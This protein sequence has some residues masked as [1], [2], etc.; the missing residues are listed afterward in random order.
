[1]TTPPFASAPFMAQFPG[2]VLTPPRSPLYVEGIPLAQA[3]LPASKALQAPS[4][5]RFWSSES[6]KYG[7]QTNEMMIVTL[8]SARLLNYISLDLPHFPSQ[9]SLAWRD[10]KGAWHWIAGPNG[11]VLQFI[12]TGSVPPVVNSAAA[13]T[14]G[15]NPY[16]YGAGHW[17]HYD[18]PIKPVTAGALL[19]AGTRALQTVINIAPGLLP[20]DASGRNCP[21]PLG[22]RNLDF[23]YRVFAPTDAPYR[24]RH[25]EIVTERQSFAVAEDINGSPVQLSMRENRASDLLNGVPWKCAPQPMS[26]AVVSL[27][28]DVRGPAGQAQVIDRFYI[29]PTTSGVSL[30]LY[31]A[32]TPP[33]AGFQAVDTPLG[34]PFA[35]VNGSVLPAVDTEGLMFSGAIGWLDLAAQ[36]TGIDFTSPWWMAWEIQ[37]QF[38]AADP[39]S[40]MVADTG[41]VQLWYSAGTWYFT[42]YGGGN[43]GPILA[44]WPAAH[45]ANDRLQFAAGW[46]GEL[47]SCWSAQGG[48]MT[49]SPVTRLPATSIIRFGAVQQ[50]NW[51]LTIW[52]GNYRLTSYILKQEAPAPDLVAGG[53]PAQFTEFAAGPQAYTAPPDGP[54][55]TT[56]NA[57]ARF[58][59]SLVLGPPSTGLAPYGFAGGLGTA[60]T[61]ATW[62]PVQLSYRL[63]AGLVQF[64][65]VL[66]CG[67]KFEF[68]NLAPAPYE[69][70]TETPQ[71][72]KVFP[73]TPPDTQAGQPP[74]GS[75]LTSARSAVLSGPN[76]S[77]GSQP[78]PPSADNGMVVNAS[79][80]PQNFYADQARPRTPPGPG[81]ALPTEALYGTDAHAAEA[82][83]RQGGSLYNFQPWLA[84]PQGAPKQAV[85]GPEIYQEVSVT[86]ASRVAYFAGLARLVMYRVDYTATN[87]TAEYIDTFGDTAGIDPA[88]LANTT[89]GTTI[90]WTWTPGLLSVPVNLPPGSVAQ[91]SS[92]VFSS[93]HQV[94]GV[95]FAALEAAPYQLLPDPGFLD[96]ALPFVAAVGDALPLTVSAGTSSPLGSLVMCSRAP[97]Q[98]SWAAM[99]ASYPLW[100]AFTAPALSWLQLE[101]NPATSPYGGLAYT[102]APVTVSAAGRVHIAA[103]VFAAQAL[104]TPLFLQ[105]LDGATGSV[106]AEQQVAAAGGIV[107]EWFASF[108]LGAVQAPSS[109][110][111]AQ[112]A[113]TYPAWNATVGQPWSVIDTFTP[114]LGNTLSWQLIQYGLTSDIWGVDDVSIFEDSIL[115][116]F[117]NDGGSTWWPA[118]D[119]NANP[120]GALVF[121]VPAAGT[122]NKLSWRLLGYRPNLT[123]GSLAVR[124]WYSCYPRG[125]PP[126]VPGLPHGPN[127]SHRDHYGQIENDP[128][129]QTWSGPVPQAWYFAYSQLLLQGTSYVQPDP[130]PL[131]ESALLLGRGLVVPAAELATGPVTYSDIYSDRYT[132]GYGVPDGSDIFTDNGG[133]GVYQ[134]YTGPTP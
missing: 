122:G 34:G 26:R 7:D 30:N 80:A 118:Y 88:S 48:T 108:T 97:G 85:T 23:G 128:Y 134:S 99:M 107:T 79:L 106:L 28:A 14:A 94:T 8:S 93:A 15:Q 89:T 25:P 75:A 46:D 73:V 126:R 47:L 86:A 119:V 18:E 65:P 41:I 50:P 100:S 19:V 40:Y 104:T 49:M 69:F 132:Y 10:A 110:T 1:M 60:W 131:P 62:I 20:R 115:W 42:Q 35:T 101:G 32:S 102:G 43:P 58:D 112:V 63:T 13:L 72:A 84:S 76:S 105:L 95:Q 27:Y 33:A 109:Y 111:W 124:P 54:G 16:H 71:K 4:G 125:V 64:P 116:E 78:V 44:S 38:G 12:I 90:P 61:S 59:L 6:R 114:P 127:V 36:G 91:L 68:T 5:Q 11:I 52:P 130:S 3:A 133:N 66:A 21:Y 113:A 123:V 22:V 29:E 57:C 67:F 53:V 96:P 92:P 117:S 82:L 120:N 121:P 56:V 129:W 87:D 70:Y 2:S 45:N 83:Q 37:P 17:I 98:I 103:R 24:S 51:S 39:G 81:S 31:Y 74:R 55:P 9:Y 77:P